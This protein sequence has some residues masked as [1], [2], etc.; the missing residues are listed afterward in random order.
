[1]RPAN[2]ALAPFL[3]SCPNVITLG[4][5]A[6]IGDYS[7]EERALLAQAR[8]IF[9]PT[10]RFVDVFHAARKI[11]FP[12]YFNYRIQRSRIL[13]ATLLGYSGCPHPPMRIY[14]GPKQKLRIPMDFAY[15]FVLM[16]PVARPETRHLVNDGITLQRLTAT[17]NPVIVQAHEPWRETIRLTCVAFDCLAAIRT[18]FTDAE[19]AAAGPVPGQQLLSMDLWG[20]TRKLLATARLDDMA[21]EWGLGKDGWQ[22]IDMGRPPVLVDSS[23]GILHRHRHV[24]RLITEGLL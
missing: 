16:G 1:M 20:N 15:P 9:Y 24:C 2:I 14:F 3:R 21:V 8:R 10:I 13:Q 23:E 4:I 17:Y 22:L 5:R 7:V 12:S 18:R 6:L 19:P 11:C